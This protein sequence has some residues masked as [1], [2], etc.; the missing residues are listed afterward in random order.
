MSRD[1]LL[2]NGCFLCQRKKKGLITFFFHFEK[3]WTL[4]W[5][6]FSLF[7]VSWVPSIQFLVKHVKKTWLAAPVEYILDSLEIDELNSV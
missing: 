6:T 7:G 2:A 1:Y 4:W 3:T 5:L